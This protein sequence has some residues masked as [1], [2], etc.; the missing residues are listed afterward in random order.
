MHRLGWLGRAAI[1]AVVATSA[2]VLSATAAIA[3]DGCIY[4]P[5]LQQWVCH[6][7]NPP[8]SGVRSERSRRRVRGPVRGKGTRIRAMTSCSGGSTIRMV[9]TTQS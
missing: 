4:E 2:A 9:A 1:A 6:V 5:T 7:V 3:R 8:G